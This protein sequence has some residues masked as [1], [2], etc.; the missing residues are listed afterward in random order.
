MRLLYWAGCVVL[1][2]WTVY[3]SGFFG[4]LMHEGNPEGWASIILMIA[5]GSI[6]ALISWAY[7]LGRSKP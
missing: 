6:T 5:T 2:F 4:A 3:I 7:A 1:A